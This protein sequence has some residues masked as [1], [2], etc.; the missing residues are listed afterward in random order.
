MDF[1]ICIIK[2]IKIGRYT[3]IDVTVTGFSFEFPTI[4][5]QDL[6]PRKLTN[7]SWKAIISKGNILP[8]II[9]SGAMFVSGE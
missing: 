5:I 3:Y 9:F 4:T 6:L 2:E 8:N 7:V 1:V